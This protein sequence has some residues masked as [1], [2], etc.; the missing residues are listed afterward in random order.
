MQSYRNSWDQDP[1]VQAKPRTQIYHCFRHLAHQAKFPLLSTLHCAS[2]LKRQR[3]RFYK[4]LTREKRNF[5]IKTFKAKIRNFTNFGTHFYI[6]R[7]TMLHFGRRK[8][9]QDI[10]GCG[11]ISIDGTRSEERLLYALYRKLTCDQS[12]C[13][14]IYHSTY[15]WFIL[16]Y[17]AIARDWC[18]HTL[19]FKYKARK[20]AWGPIR[21]YESQNDSGNIGFS[22]E[23]KHGIHLAG[24]FCSRER[25]DHIGNSMPY[26]LRIMP[27]FCNVPQLFFFSC[28]LTRVVSHHSSGRK[29]SIVTANKT[30]I[31][32]TSKCFTI[33]KD[34]FH[35]TFTKISHSTRTETC[36]IRAISISWQNVA[37]TINNHYQVVW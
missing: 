5:Q 16:W 22:R 17:E 30:C 37:S 7:P 24:I 13:G 34:S 8:M 26:S 4:A 18:D 23:V 36:F 15:D 6:W 29:T 3:S 14:W 20:M 2:T 32:K 9:L 21:A 11:H 1:C 28:L 25:P 31:E 10:P 19:N 27:A 35:D 12:S 33:I